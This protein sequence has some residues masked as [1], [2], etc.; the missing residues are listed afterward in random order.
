MWVQRRAKFSQPQ[1]FDDT[2]P[3]F[4]LGPI[5]RFSGHRFLH[6]TPGKRLRIRRTLT[7][8]QGRMALFDALFVLLAGFA[9][10]SS[11]SRPYQPALLT[12]YSMSQVPSLEGPHYRTSCAAGAALCAHARSQG[13]ALQ[14]RN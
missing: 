1:S 10:R 12:V 7:C 3:A 5:A 6:R 14:E 8:E 13:A 4:L 11:R 2:A 9:L